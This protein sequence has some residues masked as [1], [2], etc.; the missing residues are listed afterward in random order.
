MLGE[1]NYGYNPQPYTPDYSLGYGGTGDGLRVSPMG[2]SMFGGG[3]L[4]TPGTTPGGGGESGFNFLNR[5]NDKGVMT[6]QGWG[7]MALGAAQGIFNAYM[8]LKQYGLAKDQ[9]AE[10]KRQ[11]GLNYDAQRNTTNAQL[12]DRQ[13]ARLASNPGAYQPVAEYM[14]QYGI[15]PRG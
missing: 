3:Q 11:F 5:Y 7:G 1:F 14:S 6:G 8:G 2:A 12:A 4:A 10:S 15:A 9:F 13:H